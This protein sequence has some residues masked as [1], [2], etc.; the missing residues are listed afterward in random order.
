MT[1]IR[2]VLP[3]PFSDAVASDSDA[4]SLQR[5]ASTLSANAAR[6]DRRADADASTPRCRSAAAASRSLCEA[7]DYA[8]EGDTG[9]NFFD[10]RGRLTSRLP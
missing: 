1:S 5:Y 10:A 9:L 8:A 4:G 7:L 6:V 3:V 2:E